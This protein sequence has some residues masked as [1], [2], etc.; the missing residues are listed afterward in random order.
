MEFHCIQ[1][2]VKIFKAPKLCQLN[3]NIYKSIN[4]TIVLFVSEKWFGLYGGSKCIT[5]QPEPYTFIARILS[6]KILMPHPF[7]LIEGSN[8]QEQ[9]TLYSSDALF[10]LRLKQELWV[11]SYDSQLRCDFV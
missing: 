10:H 1:E 11:S 4:K 7:T 5:I 6:K 9:V 8:S 2:K 3:Q